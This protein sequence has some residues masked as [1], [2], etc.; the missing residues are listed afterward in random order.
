[1]TA[2]AFASA[3]EPRELFSYRKFWAARF[4]PAPFLPMSRQDIADYL[5]LTI[6]TVSRM[7]TQLQ[8]SGVIVLTGLRRMRVSNRPALQKLLRLP[9]STPSRSGVLASGLSTLP[10]TRAPEECRSGVKTQRRGN[11]MQRDIYKFRAGA[12]IAERPA[13]AA[14]QP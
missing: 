7:F 13:V 2:A 9:R 5:G 11:D 3:S 4:G 6:E 12:A 1:L 8:A 10:S 14:V